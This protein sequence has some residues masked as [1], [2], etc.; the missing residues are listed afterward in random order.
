[1]YDD[2]AN[3][4]PQHNQVISALQ[5]LLSNKADPNFTD[6]GQGTAFSLGR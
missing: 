3:I 4:C 1:M 2:L 6:G 5:V